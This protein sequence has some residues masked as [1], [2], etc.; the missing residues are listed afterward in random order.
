M[1]LSF[2]D[3]IRRRILYHSSAVTFSFLLA[4]AP[5]FLVIVNI[6]TYLPILE[7]E[8]IGRNLRNFF[9]DY[10]HSVLNELFEVK[11]RAKKVSAIALL[12]SYIFSVNFL[13]NLNLAVKEISE[14]NQG[15]HKGYIIW[16]IF[17]LYLL[18]G[19]LILTVSFGIS[20]YLKLLIPEKL[21]GGFDLINIIP[22]TFLFFILYTAYQKKIERLGTILMVSLITAFIVSFIQIPFTFYLSH[23]YRGNIFYGSFS[24]LMIFLLWINLVFITVLY[25]FALIQRLKSR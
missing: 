8:T 22:G 12:I 11:E 24:T 9:P 21:I 1:V 19:I 20:I 25:G 4:T 16:I 15:L 5:L 23:L 10:T 3:A 7:P 18:I 14:G 2:N 17:P 6:G 13:K